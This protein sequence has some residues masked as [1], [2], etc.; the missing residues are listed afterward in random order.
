MENVYRV[1]VVQLKGSDTY[2]VI[3]DLPSI[4][5]HFPITLTLF[6]GSREHCEHYQ[7]WVQGQLIG[8][9]PGFEPDTLEMLCRQLISLKM[10]PEPQIR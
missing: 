4:D 7:G 1:E 8:L 6:T 9:N 2:Q 3:F 5:E 10:H